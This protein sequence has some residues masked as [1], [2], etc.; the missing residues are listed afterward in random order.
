MLVGGTRRDHKTGAAAVVFVQKSSP[1]IGGYRFDSSL[2]GGSEQPWVAKYSNPSTLPSVTN[3]AD[4]SSDIAVAPSNDKVVMGGEGSTQLH[5]YDYTLKNGFGNVT[6]R[7][8]DSAV[9]TEFTNITGVAF[10]KNG[11]FLAVSSDTYASLYS[12]DGSAI[13]ARLVSFASPASFT[14]G[15]SL[16]MKAGGVNFWP[17]TDEPADGDD[18]ALAVVWHSGTGTN[19]DRIH[20][21][22]ISAKSLLGV[23]SGTFSSA[24]SYAGIKNYPPQISP[25]LIG[26]S[27]NRIGF[28]FGEADRVKG[29]LVSDAVSAGSHDMPGGSSN[30]YGLYN[31]VK[32]ATFDPHGRL[33][34][35]TD[36]SP[37]IKLYSQNSSTGVYTLLSDLSSDG[38]TWSGG[39]INSLAYDKTQD[40]LFVA[41][42]TSPYLS[43]IQMT[44]TGFGNKYADMASPPASAVIRMSLV[45]DDQWKSFN[46]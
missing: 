14:T 8:N 24:G 21:Y 5:I 45:Y 43:A 11:K 1:F 40:I 34:V 9:P 37:F 6:L 19:A 18:E 22:G 12:W 33:I 2:D 42:Q 39:E 10:S 28:M 32:Y 44:E 38:I 23:F 36:S 27:Q 15:A 29:Y 20:T 31:H 17:Y 4:H 16:N 7:S 41:H 35:A 3:A 26:T 46:A 30:T 25:S 13:D